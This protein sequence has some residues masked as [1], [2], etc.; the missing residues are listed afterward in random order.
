MSSS[1]FGSAE[2]IEQ[3]LAKYPDGP[4]TVAVGFAS[5]KGIAWLA[6]H[7]ANRP[8]TLLIGNCRKIHFAKWSRDERASAV[9]FLNRPDV[10]VKNWYKKRPTPSEAHLKVWVAHQSTAPGVLLGS[11]NLTG[12]GL[13]RNREA[14]AEAADPDRSRIAQDVNGL[15]AKAWDVKARLLGYLSEHP[16]QQA[17]TRQHAPKVRRRGCLA[18]VVSAATVVALL[19]AALNVW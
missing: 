10:D 14:V 18:A 2:R 4:L 3:F 5:V 11:A 13:F 12:A 15:V 1:E 16:Q 19:V 9:A 7:A 8:V 6:R 17:V